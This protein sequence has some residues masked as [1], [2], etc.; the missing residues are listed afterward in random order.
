MKNDNSTPLTAEQSEDVELTAAE[1][2]ELGFQY[3]TNYAKQ[4]REKIKALEE[5]YF[6]AIRQGHIQSV[7]LEGPTRRLART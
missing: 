5:K 1:E 6:F 7:W 4:C 3:W 2:N